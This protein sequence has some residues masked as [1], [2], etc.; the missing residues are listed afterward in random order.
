MDRNLEKLHHLLHRGC[1]N[2]WAGV[3]LAVHSGSEH[4]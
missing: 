4:G 2:V 1:K 3:N